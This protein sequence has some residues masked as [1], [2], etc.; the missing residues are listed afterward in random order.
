M[1]D[2]WSW[3]R[4]A[5]LGAAGSATHHN[6]QAYGAVAHIENTRETIN[7]P[8]GVFLFQIEPNLIFL[9]RVLP[10]FE[11]RQKMLLTLIRHTSETL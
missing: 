9:S 5:P 8:R 2:D 3:K 10:C 7:N 11:P 6:S 4:P 1:T